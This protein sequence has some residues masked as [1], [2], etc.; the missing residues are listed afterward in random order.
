METYPND[1]YINY[2]WPGG[3]GSLS[4]DGSL[5]MYTLGRTLRRRYYRLFPP[6][7]LYSGEQ[8][9][10]W[11]SSTERTLMSC[12]SFLAGFMPPL[13]TQNPLPIVWQPISIHSIPNDVDNVSKRFHLH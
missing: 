2:T 13:A 5:Q 11:S 6:D 7:G 3:K 9:N 1:P 8:M 10:I 4:P 12:Q